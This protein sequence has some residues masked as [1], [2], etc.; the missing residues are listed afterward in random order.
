MNMKEAMNARHSVR[1]YENKEIPTEIISVLK[2]KID[3]CNK[4]VG[5]L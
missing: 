2:E 4:E 5:L 1:S 3:A